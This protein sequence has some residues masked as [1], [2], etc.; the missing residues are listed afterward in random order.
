VVA[1][2][3]NLADP[4]LLGVSL[5]RT[6]IFMAKEEL[7][8]S[9]LTAYFLS[10]FGSFPVHRGKLDRQALRSSQQV[11]ADGL[12]LAMFPEASRSRSARLKAAMPGSALIACHS[13][14]P[15]LPVG[16]IGTEQL[17]GV[18]WLFRRPRVTINIGKPFSLPPVEGKL[19]REKLVEYTDFIMQR[20]AELLPPQ[21]RG[22]YAGKKR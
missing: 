21:Y 12:A 11:L 6:V 5:G 16:I 13:G 9:R 4:P 19:T 22:V 17:R 10:G 2:H 7:F 3:L 1:N 20:I 18:G 8:R 14:V 15:I